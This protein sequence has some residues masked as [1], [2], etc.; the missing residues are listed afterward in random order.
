MKKILIFI[1]LVCACFSLA[2]CNLFNNILGTNTSPSTSTKTSNV[3]STTNNVASSSNTTTTTTVPS[4][5][6]TTT[7]TRTSTTTVPSTTRTTTSTRPSTTTVPSTTRT[8]TSTRTSTSTIT[9]SSKEE[10]LIA[11]I[12]K[13]SFEYVYGKTTS[14]E[15]KNDIK[16]YIYTNGS[17]SFS[18]ISPQCETQNVTITFQKGTQTKT[19]SISIT[20][21]PNDRGFQANASTDTQDW[22]WENSSS[23]FTFKVY[24]ENNTGKA[25]SSFDIAIGYGVDGYVRA[26]AE[27]FNN[28]K[29]NNQTIKKGEKVTWDF[30]IYRNTSYVAYSNNNFMS[31][32]ESKSDK[33]YYGYDYNYWLNTDRNADHS[34]SLVYYLDLHYAY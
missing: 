19:K 25:I 4:T 2:S 20:I 5:T 1:V 34:L 13:T 3:Q 33:L 22:D 11:T 9:S 7:S 24:F 10:E 27:F 23:K 6:R 17:V 8:T 14:A 12:S 30:T 16:S 26:Y 32:Y 18:T 15:I 21:N 28:I 31:L 29:K